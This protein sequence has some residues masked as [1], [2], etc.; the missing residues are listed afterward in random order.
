MSGSEG[1]GKPSGYQKGKYF[2]SGFVFFS[3][4][5]PSRIWHSEGLSED[6]RFLC[7]KPVR[8]VTNSGFVNQDFDWNVTSEGGMYGFWSSPESPEEMGLTCKASVS[9]QGKPGTL[10]GSA[11]HGSLSREGTKV[12]F[13]K[14][15]QKET[16]G[17]NGSLKVLSE[18]TGTGEARW[19]MCGSASV[20]RGG[21][22]KSI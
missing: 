8:P 7:I 22:E 3:L 11:V 21:T 16:C 20:P 2:P 18:A 1:F 6:I 10:V 13:M 5:D 9:P 17:C 12:A 4:P 15:G 19:R 14:D